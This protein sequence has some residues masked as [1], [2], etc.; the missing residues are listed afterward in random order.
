MHSQKKLGTF[1]ASAICGNDITSSCLIV[2]ALTISYAG[3]WAFVALAIV[4]GV[5][6]LY[7]RIYGE[8]VGA[9]PMNGGAYNVLINN[10]TK[11]NASIA[12]CGAI[13]SYMG[14]LL[15]MFGV[16][17]MIGNALSILVLVL[18]P[19]GMFLWR[20]R[21]E[22]RVLLQALDDDYA[23]YRKRTK[24]LIPFIY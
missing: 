21:V 15:T 12:A 13:L 18:P 9:L 10:T 19:L 1:A 11:T 7:R 2:S 4:A 3:P 17:L 16:G 14:A 22:E 6:Y 24:R 20:I 8:V 23:N 5:L